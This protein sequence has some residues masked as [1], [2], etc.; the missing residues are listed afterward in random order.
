MLI[1]VFGLVCATNVLEDWSA[2]TDTFARL[3]WPIYTRNQNE[4]RFTAYADVGSKVD[5]NLPYQMD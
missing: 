1:E 4:N 3:A 5:T 2:L